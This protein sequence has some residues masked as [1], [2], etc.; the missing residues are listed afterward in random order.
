MVLLNM[1]LL[2]F[3]QELTAWWISDEVKCISS[4]FWCQ[5]VLLLPSIVNQIEEIF[6]K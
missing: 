1:L 6:M 3:L 2:Y 4:L 5:E